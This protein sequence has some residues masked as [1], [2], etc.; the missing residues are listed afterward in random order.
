MS[1]DQKL[2]NFINGFP[3]SVGKVVDFDLTRDKVLNLNL[4]GNNLEL[5]TGIIADIQLFSDWVAD[6]LALNHCKYGIGGYLEHRTIYNHSALF[7][8]AA[9][10]RCLH[11]GVDIWG[12]AATPVYAAFDG[13]VHSFKDNNQPGDYGPTI[14]LEHNL[15]GLQLYTLYGHLNRECLAP[16][17]AG[18]PVKANDPIAQFGHATVNGNWPPHLHFQVMF[19]MQG[20]KGDYPGACRLSEKDVW[21][22]NTSDP[23]WILQFPQAAIM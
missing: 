10:P 12:N 19:D 14:I 3:G 16:L 7:N 18:M 23:N 1:P 4:T 22:S 9:E 20:Y 21:C 17:Y 5:T 13:R 2:K 11:L 8:T 6:K 15:N